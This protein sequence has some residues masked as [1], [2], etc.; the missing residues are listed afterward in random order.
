MIRETFLVRP[1]ATYFQEIPDPRC[2]REH[3]HSHVEVLLL[4]VLGFLA[5]K[6]SLRR[7]VKWAKRNQEKLKKNLALKNGIPSLST[8]SRIACGTDVE[9]L[10][11]AFTDWIGNI[12]STKGMHIAIDGK[13]LRAAAEKIKDQKAPYILNAMDTATNLVIAQAAIPEKTNETSAIPKLL[14]ILDITGSTITIDA[15]GATETILRMIEE[16]DGYFVQQIKK[17]C[18]ATYQE[19][20]DIFGGLEEEKKADPGKFAKES[21]DRYSEYNSFEKNR[22]R[23]E[24]RNVQCYTNDDAVGKI[25]KEL[26]FIRSIASS[27]QVRIPK[28]VDK[29]GTDVTP[30]KETFLKQG[31]RKCPKPTEGDDLT[32]PV[33]K[34]GLVSNRVLTAEEFARYRR[35]HW[36]IENCLHYVLDETFSEDKCA[37]KKSKNTLC[38][39]RKTAYNVIRL[40]QMDEPKDR[41][42]VIDVIDE[43]ADDLSVATRWI[44][45]PIP[46]FY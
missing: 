18:S 32:D 11:L 28:E 23:M 19:I 36:R 41:V 43:I 5:G 27:C 34:V 40:M 37:A 39:L 10:T 42:Q 1:L 30:D 6:T 14:E 16:K 13:A 38:V 25:R 20:Q 12:V 45:N 2:A 22:E 4:I 8:F 15:I 21:K 3:K 35:D 29:D 46:S 31:S 7:I 26:P 24:Y 44:F 33:Q 17:N 9:L